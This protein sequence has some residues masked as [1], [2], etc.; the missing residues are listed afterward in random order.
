[1]T[2]QDDFR[3]AVIETP[4]VMALAELCAA[5][6]CEAV[7]LFRPKEHH[8]EGGVLIVGLLVGNESNT[9]EIVQQAHRAL[10]AGLREGT[11][12]DMSAGAS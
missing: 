10:Q 8:D 1:M 12:I 7:L 4:Q 9:A 2:N 6:D 3:R 11:P 5:G